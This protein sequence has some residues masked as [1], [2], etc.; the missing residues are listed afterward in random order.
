MGWDEVGDWKMKMSTTAIFQSAREGG[1]EEEKQAAT[2]RRNAG[3]LA[4]ALF[5]ND[6]SDRVELAAL[7]D[8]W[9][10]TN[11]DVGGTARQAVRAQ[12]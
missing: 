9:T 7:P 5:L 10:R 12:R 8:I 1:R 2:P 3:R 4:V 11:E 6:R